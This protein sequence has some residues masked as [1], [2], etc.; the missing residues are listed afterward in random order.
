MV[1][2]VNIEGLYFSDRQ[3][4]RE[5]LCSNHT[6]GVLCMQE[7]HRGPGAIRPRVA[8]TN[9]VAEI[10]HGQYGSALFIRDPCTSESRSTSSIDNII[11]IIFIF[12]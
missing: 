12:I 7:T 9:L 10:V 8:G 6:C 5:E 2:S 3:Q 4:I 1:M 11:I